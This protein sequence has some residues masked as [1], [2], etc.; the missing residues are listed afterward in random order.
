MKFIHWVAVYG[1]AVSSVLGFFQLKSYLKQKGK[2][3]VTAALLV[4]MNKQRDGK[5]RLGLH[6]LKRGKEPVFISNLFYYS[7][8]KVIGYTPLE[9]SPIKLTD[10][11]EIKVFSNIDPILLGMD[12]L[13]ICDTMSRF[14]K[15]N[16]KVLKRLKEQYEKIELRNK[17][18]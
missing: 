9:K 4:P 5:I 18:N 2:I 10:E 14:Y 11:G 15:I 12:C 8:Q 6:V 13:G 16:K 17:G 3:K 1:A 7:K